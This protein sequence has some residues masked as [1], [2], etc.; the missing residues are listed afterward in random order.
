M[1]GLPWLVAIGIGTLLGAVAWGGTHGKIAGRVTDKDGSP[2]SA[3]NV[4][5]KGT[6]RGAF[7]DRNGFYHVLGVP[8]GT[9]AVIATHIGY[10]TV[11]Q[12]DVRIRADHTTMLDFMLEQ[13]VLP[14]VEI[15]VTAEKPGIARDITG[16]TRSIDADEIAELPTNT[17]EDILKLQSGIVGAHGKIHMRGGRT[18]ELAYVIDGH[19]TLRVESPMYG[20][21]STDINAEAIEE[22]GIVTGGYDA[23]YG[24]AM[25]GIVN[26]VTKEALDRSRAKLRF[27]TSGLQLE[28]PSTNLNERLIEGSFSGP[29]WKEKGVGLLLSGRLSRAGNHHESGIRGADG[30]PS[31]KLS[32]EAF[33]FDNGHNLFAKVSFKPHRIGRLAFSYTYDN[34]EWQDYVHEYKYIPDSAYVQATTSHLI[35]ANF[36]ALLSDDLFYE[37]RASYYRTDYLLNYSGFHY[38]EYSSGSGLR[39]RNQEFLLT[40]NN[41]W[42]IDSKVG[43]YAGAM[44]L[45]W[46]AHRLHHLKIGVEYKRHDT[47]FYWIFGPN[48][49][50][51]WQYLNDYRIYPYEGVVYCQDKMELNRLVVRAGLRFDFFHPRIDNYIADPNDREGSRRDAELKTQ[52]SPR[53][54]IAYQP[55]DFSILHAAYGYFYQRPS[56]FELYQDLSRT[57]TVLMPLIGNPDLEPEKTEC[58]EVGIRVSTSSGSTL[59]AKAFSKKTRNLIGAIWQPQGPSVPA[60]YAYYLNEDFADVKGLEIEA[61]ASHGATSGAISYTYSQAE[62]SA[63]TQWEHYAFPPH[64]YGDHPLRLAPLEFDQRHSI[65]AR[66]AL[67]YG[68]GEGPRGFARWLFENT[69]ITLL[70]EYG[71]GLPFTYNPGDSL[72]VSD[73]LNSRM[74]ASYRVDLKAVKR[75]NVGMVDLGII[76]EIRN[77]FDRKN[78]ANVYEVTGEPDDS[79]SNPPNSYEFDNDPT[80]YYD[81]RT[82]YLGLEV[83]F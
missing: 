10:Q 8:V 37:L 63:S 68:D 74:P 26:I 47:D 42:Y 9:H 40:S 62:G 69:R 45:T 77:L 24:N 21:M 54:G 48:L 57:L 16:T 56:F 50:E 35:A 60:S 59:Q 2:L 14:A 61:K 15:I 33:G 82:L 27:T 19:R 78:V 3:V 41:L 71:S 5:L 39:D 1:R 67:F 49:P 20:G 81:P 80:H 31:G 65:V 29:L 7:T 83:D 55:S 44:D 53:L 51:E 22:I 12:E 46:Q 6:M 70:F 79:G 13:T 32:G 43:T 23:E 52:V 4:I 76:L 17:L 28:T 64:V 66:M 18:G 34:H 11:T 25:S 30:Q 73:R 38:T 75:F 72:Y 58:S 36:T